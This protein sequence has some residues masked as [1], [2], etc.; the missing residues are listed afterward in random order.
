MFWKIRR[1]CRPPDF[2]EQLTF[3]NVRLGVGEWSPFFWHESRYQRGAQLNMKQ[4][5]L[6]WV[7]GMTMV[8]SSS[9]QPYNSNLLI[10]PGAETGDMT[11]WSVTANGGNGW[12][13]SL[14]SLVHFGS[15]SFAT[16]FGWDI[17]N[18][19]EYLLAADLTAAEPDAQPSFMFNEWMAKRA[20]SL[21]GGQYYLTFEPLGADDNLDDPIAT[22]S[23]E[24][25]SSPLTLSAGTAWFEDSHTFGDYGIGAR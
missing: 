16:S 18:Q 8:V 12:A 10:N 1:P 21:H 15:Y 3:T 6:A 4:T 22:F 25:E 13:L 19:T 11:G 23:F 7:S 20:D 24:S 17:P 14:G 9:A 2:T 5:I